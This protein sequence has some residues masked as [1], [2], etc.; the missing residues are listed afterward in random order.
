MELWRK[1]VVSQTKNLGLKKHVLACGDIGSSYDMFIMLEEDIVVS[2]YFLDYAQKA[3]ICYRD[4]ADVCGISLYSY[5]VKE[6]DKQPLYVINDGYD[7]F[8]MQFPSSWGQVWSSKH[9]SQFRS[10]LVMNDSDALGDEYTPSYIL[11][12][13]SSSWKKQ[14]ARYMAHT[15]K[16]FVFP[17]VGLTTN[18]GAHGQNHSLIHNLFATQLLLGERSWAFPS[19]SKGVKYNAKFELTNT[20][21]L[22]GR[23]KEYLKLELGENT[24]PSRS[25]YAKYPYGVI[26]YLKLT[27]YSFVNDFNKSLV[28]IKRFLK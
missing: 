7:V 15:N 20:D 3:M 26:F 2:P 10:W 23:Y 8:F 25:F 9:W 1:K 28:K 17:R 21:G 19:F 4:S 18:Y 16:Y 22:P 14:Y 27:W 5:D 24:S 12:W 13:P 6:I 11:K